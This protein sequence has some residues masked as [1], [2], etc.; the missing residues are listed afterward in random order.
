MA[1]TAITIVS[2]VSAGSF[3]LLGAELADRR[4]RRRERASFRTE[5]ALE[6]AAME[7]HIWGD[8]WAELQ[9][10][11]E[12]Q[13]ARMMVGGVPSDLIDAFDELSAACFRDSQRSLKM[14]NEEMRGI[15]VSLLHARKAT[16]KAI[17]AHLLEELDRNKRR[18]D[19]LDAAERALDRA[20]K[21]QAAT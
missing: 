14:S 10:H 21:S 8:D 7:R 3:A 4:A 11:I 9:A 12:R 5:T 15:G 20:T 17:R 16:H 1:D 18:R 2:I 13:R 19:A 6:L